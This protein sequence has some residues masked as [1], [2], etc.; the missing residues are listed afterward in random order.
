[1]RLSIVIPTFNRAKLLGDVLEDLDRQDAAAAGSF[2]VVVVDDGSTDATAAVVR[3]AVERSAHRIRYLHQ[4]NAGLNAARNVGLRESAG[5]IVAYLDDDVALPSTWVTS[6][7]RGFDLH[8]HVDALAGRILLQFEGEE[9]AWITGGLRHYLS[10]YDLGERPSIIS[11]HD[12]PRGACFAVRR[13]ALAQIEPFRAGLDRRGTSLLSSGEKELFMRLHAAGAVTMYWPES[14]V[15]HRVPA[16]RTTVAWFRRRAAAQGAGDAVIARLEGRRLRLL[17]EVVRL[18][19]V[20]PI[21]VKAAISR[22]GTLNADL[23]IR[24][25][26][27]RIAAEARQ[28]SSLALRRARQLVRR[29]SARR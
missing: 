3:T 10:E 8:P 29:A 17:R 23:W 24:Y 11:P 26:A 28:T 13:R 9:P 27:S 14:W 18:G 25:S 16:E 2:E 22:G 20:A 7:L 12:Y 15:L 5:E 21:L 6:T 4:P 1:M 19:R